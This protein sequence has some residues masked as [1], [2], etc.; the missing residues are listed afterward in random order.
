MIRDPRDNWAAIAAGVDSYYKNFGE[1]RLEALASTVFRIQTGFRSLMINTKI[2]DAQEYRAVKF[3]DL[4]ERTNETLI[5]LTDWLGVE[6]TLDL[7]VPTRA[8]TNY[9]GNSHDG[10]RFTR[11]SSDN[12][13][14]FKERLPAEEIAVIE[15]LCEPIMNFFDYQLT[16]DPSERLAAIQRFYSFVNS[17]YFYYDKHKEL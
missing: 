6:R 9:E 11:V 13:G 3:E 2:S 17:R 4:V 10:L 5:E 12:V 16:T 8:G 15:A 14:R 7:Q 1:N